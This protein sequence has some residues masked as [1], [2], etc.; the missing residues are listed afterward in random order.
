MPIDTAI[1]AEAGSCRA[2]ARW[3][4]SVGQGAERTADQVNTT[5]QQSSGAWEGAA[6]DGFRDRATQL[7]TAGDEVAGNARGAAAAMSAFADAVDAVT[8]DMARARA[9]AA[10]A[11]LPVQGE[12]IGEPTAVVPGPLAP[13]APPDVA[14]GHR[15]ATD[16]ATAQQR[17]FDEAATIAG[18]ARTRYTEAQDRLRSGLTAP[19]DWLNSSATTWTFRGALVPAVT[20][21]SLV[22]AARRWADVAEHY[23]EEAR[24]WQQALHVEPAAPGASSVDPR[25]RYEEARRLAGRANGAAL[26]NARLL[27]GAHELPGMGRAV[28]LLGRP[29]VPVPE[30]AT[31]LLGRVAPVLRSVPVLGVV[32]TGAGIGLDTAAGRSVGSATAKNVTQTLAATATTAGTAALL[33]LAVAGGPATL[34]AVGA[35]FAV[36][37]AIGDHWDTIEGWFS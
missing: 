28:D 15:Q 26:S 37:W 21:T 29:A 9:V 16:A 36:S 24:L 2:T 19:T 30:T 11:G 35:G 6:G 25:A 20:A 10:G 14:A 17:A 4:S 32:S 1:D 34:V 3:L 13:D 8:A 27:G 31:G 33:G 22:G 18:T 12:V 23:G 7:C 5:R